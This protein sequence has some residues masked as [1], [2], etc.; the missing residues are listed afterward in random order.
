MRMKIKV[1]IK[2][3]LQTIDIDV[4]NRKDILVLPADNPKISFKV[5]QDMPE[6]E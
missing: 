5:K 3:K 1:M 4:N 2:G 6:M